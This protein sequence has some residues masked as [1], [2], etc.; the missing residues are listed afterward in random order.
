[1]RYD[2][3]LSDV[4][5]VLMHM[6]QHEGPLTSQALSGAM[7]TNPVVV[8]RILAGLR[9]HGYVRSEKGHGGGW[10]LARSLS[11]ITLLD[12]YKALGSPVLFAMGHRS[13]SPDCL[14]QQW[15]NDALSGAFNEA[16][17]LLASRFAQVT[18][19][20]LG[21]D[22]KKRMAQRKQARNCALEH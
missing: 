11:D 10:V 13:A 2:T 18:L 7:T 3:R 8:R 16:E 1:M 5:H 20:Q 9:D 17:A 12:I 4:L 19:A 14:V 22:F 6:A 21:E 15:V